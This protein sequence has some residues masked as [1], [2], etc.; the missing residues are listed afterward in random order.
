MFGVLPPGVKISE[1]FSEFHEPT[2]LQPR[3]IACW[4][5][6]LGSLAAGVIRGQE[7]RGKV[8][9]T[10]QGA[11]RL[12]LELLR[13]CRDLEVTHVSPALADMAGLLS[14]GKLAWEQ[15]VEGRITE[16]RE[17]RLTEEE[18][19]EGALLQAKNNTVQWIRA[20]LGGCFPQHAYS[21]LYSYF[22]FF[23]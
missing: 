21:C 11:G 23:R 22:I 18:T 5:S 14:S 12:S 1:S 20:Q 13:G 17:F 7:I 9:V 3:P 19:G 2:L 8:L 15:P 10:S 16:H 4:P 6:T